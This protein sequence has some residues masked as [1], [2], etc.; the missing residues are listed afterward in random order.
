MGRRIIIKS[1]VPILM[2]HSISCDAAP[3]FKHFVVSPSSFAEQMRHLRDGG[4]TPITVTQ[5]VERIGDGGNGLPD[6]PILLTFDDGFADFH[7]TALPIL[8]QCNFVATLYISSAFIGGTSAWLRR[9]HETT[10][11]MLDWTQVAE[12]A[13]CGIECGGHSHT[14]PK[15]DTLPPAMARDEIARCKGI[16]EERL[17]LEV[18]SFAY[19]FGYYN[20][21]VKRMVEE[22]GYTSAC[23]VRYAMSSLGDDRFALARLLVGAGMDLSTFAALVAGNETPI[24][25]T[26][27]RARAGVWQGVR[28]SLAHTRHGQARELGAKV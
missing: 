8:Q 27:R 2:Y 20:A 23:A 12:V 15:L 21:S 1:Q 6:R 17:G 26:F 24:L 3:R 18:A 7:A 9:E 19:P 5:F 4:Y 13:A 22:A 25:G 28:W 16:I 11:P 10:R 14:H